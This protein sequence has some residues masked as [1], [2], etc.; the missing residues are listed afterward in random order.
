[1][2]RCGDAV[3]P[4][5]FAQHVLTPCLIVSSALVPSFGNQLATEE[6]KIHD[7]HV[8]FLESC[9]TTRRPEEQ[10]RAMT[11]VVERKGRAILIGKT[12]Q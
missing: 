3:A 7:L 6:E 2:V 9:A 8:A 1:M 5:A 12:V 10:H 4:R 11:A